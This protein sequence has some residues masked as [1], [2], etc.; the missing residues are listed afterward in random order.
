MGETKQMGEL[1]LLAAGA[2]LGL[3]VILHFIGT[4]DKVFMPL[5]IGMVAFFVGGVVISFK[6]H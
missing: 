6:G 4:T 1:L 3:I 2:L 5:V